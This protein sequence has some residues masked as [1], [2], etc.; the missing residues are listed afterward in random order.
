MDRRRA[1]SAFTLVELL[2]VIAIIGVLVA[3]LLPAVQAARE[4]ARRMQ[5]GNNLKQIGLALHNYMDTRKE[6]PAGSSY[7]RPEKTPTW[8]V[9]LFPFFEQQGITA[10]Y[11]F[12]KY[13][14]EE[15]NLT[16][17]RSVS[18]PT[19]VC[20]S[21][22]DAANPILENRRQEGGSRNPPVAHGLWYT[23]SMGPT[24][25]DQCHFASDAATLQYTCLGCAYGTITPASGTTPERARTPCS[26]FHPPINNPAE[27]VNNLDTCAGLFCRRHLPTK[28]RTISDGLSNTIMVGETLPR[29]WIWNCVFCDNF[30]VS[31]TH[32]PI[33]TME[34]WDIGYTDGFDHSKRSGFKSEHPTGV[35]ILMGDGSVHFFNQNIDYIS[36]NM[37]GSRAQD[38]VPTEKPF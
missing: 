25:P 31:S 30:P 14:N 32:I 8:A 10:R 16:L 24:I 2:V 4:A 38:D 20:P 6:L 33:N 22:I 23:G 12:D 35:N 28:I 26:R 17:A 9:S 15:P 27:Q 21:D 11:D 19:L 5:C 1:S 18:I 37:L 29:H 34:G 13:A 3:L 36:Y 7:Q